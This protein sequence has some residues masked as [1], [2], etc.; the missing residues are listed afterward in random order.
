MDG[1]SHY[2]EAERLV[3][4]VVTADSPFGHLR[5]NELI[6]AAQV[7]ATLALAAATALAP[8]MSHYEL[9]EDIES[10]L[11]AT[12][13]P[14]NEDEAPD[15]QLAAEAHLTD[16]TERSSD[17]GRRDLGLTGPTEPAAADVDEPAPDPTSV[18]RR[19][20]R[21]DGYALATNP[22]GLNGGAF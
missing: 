2:R 12:C 17:E 16:S 21:L 20:D 19:L 10:W 1:P 22:Y 8:I 3:D 6:A 4:A 14:D 11:V 15:A 13:T 18:D 7:H 9:P 5:P